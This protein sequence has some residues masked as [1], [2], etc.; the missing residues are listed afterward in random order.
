RVLFRSLGVPGGAA[1]Q[2][3]L[4]RLL[5]PAVHLS[6]TRQRALRRDQARSVLRHGRRRATRRLSGRS[7]VVRRRASRFPSRITDAAAGRGGEVERDGMRTEKTVVMRWAPAAGA[8]A[9]ARGRSV[10]PAV[11]KVVEELA[12]LGLPL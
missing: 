3:P 10:A 4:Q 1:D 5:E 8:S 11:E 9:R 7:A 6:R 12:L 2:G